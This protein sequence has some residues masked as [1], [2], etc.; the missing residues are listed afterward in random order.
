MKLTR[1]M[2]EAWAADDATLLEMLIVE[3]SIEHAGEIDSP[4]SPDFDRLCEKFEDELWE[5]VRAL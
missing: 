4:N 5:L 3:H 2:L 1:E